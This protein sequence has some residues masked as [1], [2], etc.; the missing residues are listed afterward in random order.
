MRN[1]I[2]FLDVCEF[3]GL[4]E[5]CN[6]S[7]DEETTIKR[8]AMMLLENG[9]KTFGALRTDV[10]D[11][12]LDKLAQH[13]PNFAGVIGWIE[14][15][16][17]FAKFAGHG[18]DFQRLLLV[19]PPGTGKT[20]FCLELADALGVPADV[21]AMN[22]RQ[23]GSFLTGMEQHWANTQPGAVFRLLARSPAINPILVLDEIEKATKDPRWDPLSGLYTLLERRTARQFADAALPDVHLNAAH[24]NWIATANSTNDISAPLLSSFNVFEI[25]R[26][27]DDEMAA[28]VQRMY[29][30]LLEDN[31]TVR[32]HVDT[33]LPTD[34]SDALVSAQQSGRDIDRTLRR[35]VGRALQTGERLSVGMMGEMVAAPVTARQKIG[36]V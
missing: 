16:L 20:T 26:L 30:R 33:Q 31:P 27:T 12:R 10:L 6:P 17:A 21:V 2:E 7:R 34:V 29:V 25:R 5:H 15:E 13:H 24:V 9:R 28:L 22:Q 14:A 32:A 36:F 4:L 1:H 3:V 35:I 23:T 19:G 18:L 11:A 8:W